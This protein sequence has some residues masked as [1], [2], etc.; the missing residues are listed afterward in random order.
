MPPH[1]FQKKKKSFLRQIAKQ[2]ISTRLV[3]NSRGSCS[4]K[5]FQMLLGCE[6]SVSMEF[7]AFCILDVCRAASQTAKNA[8]TETF[9]AH[10][11]VL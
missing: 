4:V 8:Q 9:A 7:S 1:H 6:A 2:V 11:R 3:L 5:L 10:A